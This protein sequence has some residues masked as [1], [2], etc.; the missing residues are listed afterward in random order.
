MV[1]K[2]IVSTYA[3]GRKISV[4]VSWCNEYIF[5]LIS[6]T[7]MNII[8]FSVCVCVQLSG[9]KHLWACMPIPCVHKLQTICMSKVELV[10]ELAW[11]FVWGRQRERDGLGEGVKSD[12]PQCLTF[13]HCLPT[14]DPMTSLNKRFCYRL[15]VVGETRASPTKYLP[16]TFSFVWLSTIFTNRSG[17]VK[18]KYDRIY[19]RVF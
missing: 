1:P 2:C 18:L 17:C 10:R 11:M 6:L 7:L 14:R 3:C 8:F 9:K 4:S 5:Y 16:K 13:N 15:P 19:C 12:P